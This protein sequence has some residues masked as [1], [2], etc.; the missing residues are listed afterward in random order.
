MKRVI[1]TALFGF[2]LPALAQSLFDSFFSEDFFK[3]HFESREKGGGQDVEFLWTETEKAHVLLMTPRGGKDTPLDISIKE[4]LVKV[5]GKV[6]KKETVERD[7][8]KTQSSYLSQFSSSQG[9]P[10]GADWEKGKME[11]V[12]QSIKITFPKKR[13]YRQSPKGKYLKDLS[14]LGEKI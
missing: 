4:G 12:G 9:I 11:Q 7:G 10:Q 14:V 2:C 13:G 3:D 6:V 8:V 5:S 1:L